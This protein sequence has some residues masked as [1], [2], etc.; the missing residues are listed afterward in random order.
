MVLVLLAH[1][2][3]IWFSPPAQP[4]G[5]GFLLDLVPSEQ[6]TQICFLLPG[7]YPGPGFLQAHAVDVVLALDFI[8]ADSRPDTEQTAESRMAGVSEEP[9]ASPPSGR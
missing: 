7:A 4:C 6:P 8:A 1:K 3:W 2:R 5:F 9:V